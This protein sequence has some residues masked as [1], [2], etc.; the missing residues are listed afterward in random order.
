[1]MLPLPI[2]LPA[3]D[4]ELLGSWIQRTASVYD[5][6][7][8][9]LLDRWQVAPGPSAEAIPS[10]EMRVVGADAVPVI[11]QRMR[12]PLQAV[13]AMI[14]ERPIGSWRATPMSPFACGVCRT[15]TPR[16]SPD[17]DERDGRNVGGSSALSI[18]CRWSTCK[19]GGAANWSQFES[20]DRSGGT[21]MAGSSHSEV[22]ES[23][24]C[25]G[26]PR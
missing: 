1:M 18:E 12:A 22:V 11:A 15:M 21:S 23:V 3:V 25:L 6:S 8:H 13:S 24:E 17:S 20:I 9:Q 19:I 14:P 2:V 26:G 4:N 5:L 16:G 10:V 7:A